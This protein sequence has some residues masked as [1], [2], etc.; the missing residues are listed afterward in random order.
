MRI[1][2]QQFGSARRVGVLGHSVGPRRLKEG[3]FV[4]FSFYCLCLSLFPVP[5]ISQR[6]A[7]HTASRMCLSSLSLLLPFL[8][9]I[10]GPFPIGRSSPLVS[11][12]LDLLEEEALSSSI[13]RLTTQRVPRGLTL[14]CSFYSHHCSRRSFVMFPPV[15]SHS[16]FTLVK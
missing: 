16:S 12:P 10:I 5:T 13:P 4:M 6:K 8:S 2:E 11:Q 7:S 3:H 15:L 9:E 1:P 14:V